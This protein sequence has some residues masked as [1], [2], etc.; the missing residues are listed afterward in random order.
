M[1]SRFCA[2]AL[3]LLA[4]VLGVAPGAYAPA[5]HAQ[6]VAETA[7]DYARWERLATQVEDAIED[8]RVAD[9]ELDTL[10]GQVVDARARFLAAQDANRAR[11][12]TLRSQIEVLGPP[13]AEGGTEV[14]EIATRRTELN[15]QL[16]RLQVPGLAAEEA[17]RR[18][19]GLV[20]QIDQVLRDRQA[21]ALMT[22][23]PSPLNPANW[24][25]GLNTLFSSF[26]AILGEVQNNWAEPRLRTEFQA[27]LPVI[28]AYLLFAGVLLTRGRR[29]MEQLTERLLNASTTLRGRNVWALIVSLGQIVL[30]LAG[31]LALA[32]AVKAT[33]MTALTGEEILDALPEAGFVVLAARWLGGQIFPAA[34]AAYA[35]LN[36]SLERRREGRLHSLLI[37]V[38]LALD[39]LRVPLTAPDLQPPGANAMISF[40]LIVVAGLLALRIGQLLRLHAEARPQPD[41]GLSFFDRMMGIVGRLAMVLGVLAGVLAAVGYVPAAEAVVYPAVMSLGLIGVLVLAQRLVSD[42]YGMIT[43]TGADANEALV[44]ALVGLALVVVSVPAFALVW[45]VRV[46]QLREVWQ[47]IAEGFSIGGTRISPSNLLTFFIVFVLGYTVT[48]LIQG[49]LGTSV[50]PK[51]RIEKGGQKA[52]VSGVGYLGVF[53]AGITA[54]ATAGIDLSALALVAGALS[55][56]IGFGLQ[57]IVSNFVSGIILLIERPVSEGDWIEV[58]GTMGVVRSISVRS[59]V[60]ETFDRTDVIVPNADLI[61]GTVTNWTRYNNTGRLIVPVG[62]AYGSDTRRIEAI[63]NE[64][65][66][67]QPLAVVDPAP[68][69]LFMGF[70]ADSLNFEIRLILSDVAF[71][72]AVMSDMNHEIARRFQEEGIEIPFAQRDIWLRNPEALRATP[73]PAPTPERPAPP[74]IPPHEPQEPGRPAPPPRRIDPVMGSRADLS[75]AKLPDLGSDDGAGSGGGDGR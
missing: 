13:P 34:G 63:L 11:I 25:S 35:P 61:S 8:P 9:G 49:G 12:D 22:L 69:I 21:D 16:S 66:E 59:T 73:H 10:R 71:K 68:A 50:L 23:V 62:V 29:W 45:G 65:A 6:T 24:Q 3:I 33:S 57:N 47:S 64:I 46:T 74:S 55:V 41:P 72:L 31:V 20:S 36:L 58:G 32:E 53:L 54:F 17:F 52:I 4:V 51:T 44:P 37:G 19:D 40:P 14:A 5:A 56:G 7:P 67:A 38:V 39:V 26:V 75:D 1:L 28:L 42:I 30:P 43:G 18:A 70:G 2:A 15:E 27:N 60:V 48:R